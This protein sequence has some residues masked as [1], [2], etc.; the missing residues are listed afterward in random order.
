MESLRRELREV[1]ARLVVAS[2]K[3]I[4]KTILS[5]EYNIAVKKAEAGFREFL[6]KVEARRL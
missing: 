4:N 2:E 5:D 3:Y 6:R 1:Y